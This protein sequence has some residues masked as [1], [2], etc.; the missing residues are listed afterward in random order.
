MTKD[1]LEID[2][3]GAIWVLTV[4]WVIALI[5]QS[6]GLINWDRNLLTFGVLIG[7]LTISFLTHRRYRRR[8]R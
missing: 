3:L 4:L 5:A 6:A 2:G 1:P 8:Q 7:V